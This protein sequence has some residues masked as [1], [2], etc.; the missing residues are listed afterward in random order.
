M[1]HYYKVIVCHA[2]CM[3]TEYTILTL[4]KSINNC[5]K[6]SLLESIAISI[7]HDLK[8]CNFYL[9]TIIV[10]TLSVTVM[11]TP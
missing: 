3:N 5:R 1:S 8:K 7:S 10:T 4:I 9:L 11:L 6:S 2:Y